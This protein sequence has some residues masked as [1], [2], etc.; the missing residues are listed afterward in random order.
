MGIQL[1]LDFARLS[2]FLKQQFQ[3][4]EILNFINY[5]IKYHK[6]FVLVFLIRLTIFEKDNTMGVSIYNGLLVSKRK[7]QKKH[8]V[9]L[10]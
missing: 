7:K 9:F 1:I 2:S 8:L 10:Y 4:K 3:N 5:K 6:R